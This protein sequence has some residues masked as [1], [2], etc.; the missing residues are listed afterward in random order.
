M[1]T[2]DPNPNEE[3]KAVSANNAENAPATVQPTTAAKSKQQRPKRPFWKAV[4]SNPLFWLVVAIALLIGAI[5]YFERYTQ[6]GI[7]NTY[8]IF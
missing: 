4:L 1:S 6:I 7:N 2:A 5:E 3:N 8:R